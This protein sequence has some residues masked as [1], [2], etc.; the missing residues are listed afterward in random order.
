MLSHVLQRGEEY[1][2]LF[3]RAAL[4][5]LYTHSSG[6]V[7]TPLQFTSFTRYS[8][9]TKR[10]LKCI[11][12]IPQCPFHGK[13]IPRDELG[14]PTNPEDAER[15]EKERRKLQEEQPGKRTLFKGSLQYLKCIGFGGIAP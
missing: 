3:M 15:L 7:K 10:S 6:T 9:Y 12:C 1:L 4:N 13:I 8:N 2:L 11:D 5:V 14:K